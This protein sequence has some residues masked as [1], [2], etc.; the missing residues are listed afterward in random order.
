MTL[1]Q[2]ANRL[3]DLTIDGFINGIRL[4]RKEFTNTLVEWATSS[5][6]FRLRNKFPV[7]L[8][9]PDGKWYVCINRYGTGRD[10]YDYWMPDNREQER[11]LI[12]KVR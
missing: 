7:Q 2:V 10:S 4:S 9:L 5:G 11:L 12:Q 8:D 6:A 1:H 3:Y